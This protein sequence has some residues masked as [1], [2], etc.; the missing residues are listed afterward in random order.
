M[1]AARHESSSTWPTRRQRIRAAAERFDGSEPVNLGSGQ[2]ISIKELAVLVAELT[3]YDG[4]VFWDDERPNGQPRRMLDTTRAKELF[5]F[6]ATTSLREGLA[7]TI[8]WYEA[9][10][11]GF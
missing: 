7:A 2:E 10:V 4:D 11:G 3:G 8:D 5:G 6:E 1:T 9:R